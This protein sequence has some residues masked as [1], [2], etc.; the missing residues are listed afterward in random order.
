VGD[1]R[2]RITQE[3]ICHPEQSEGSAVV[4]VP[5]FLA[6]NPKGNLLLAANDLRLPLFLL[7]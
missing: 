7:F 4:F 3:K 5:V 1:R 2:R 6:V